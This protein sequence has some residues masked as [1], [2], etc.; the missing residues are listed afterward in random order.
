MA[1]SAG[2]AYD[3][4]VVGAGSAGC[5]LAARLSEAADR[6]VLLLEAGPELRPA[7]LPDEL[8]LLSKAI[9]WPFDWGDQVLSLDERPLFYGRGRGIGGS[10]GTNGAVAMRAEPEDFATWLP[11]W[12]WDDM[13]PCFRRL[14]HDLDFGS[15][16]YHGADGPV[17]I[18]RWPRDEWTPMQLAFHDACRSLGFPDCPDHNAPGTTGVGPIPMNRVGRERYSNARAYLEPARARPNLDVRADA[19][20]HSVL[21]PRGRAVGIELATGERISAGEVVLAAGVVQDPLLLWRSGIGPPAELAALGIPVIVELPAVGSH[22]TDHFV[23]TFA[24]EIDPATA[25]DDAPSLHTILRAT[26]PGSDRVHDLQLTPWVR[27]LPDGR[28]AMGISVSLQLPDGEGA[29]AATAADPESPARITWPFA[30][31]DDNVRR[32]RDGWRLAARVVDASGIALDRDAL[33]AEIERDD[34]DI[35]ALVR[36][37]HSA[38][39]HGVG[40]CRMGVDER[41]SVVDALGRVHG[42]SGLRIVDASIAPVVPRTNTHLLVTAMAERA[43]ETWDANLASR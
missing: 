5:V 32:V 33:R 3:T 34:A 23:V 4:I 14:E 22:V 20:V 24:H 38:F 30:A 15:E 43:V 27:R 35:D 16:P 18:V 8:R 1:P 7:A 37:T 6:R 28:R 42:I 12:Q 10:S 21:A 9:S 29:I 36:D 25:P 19:H 40:T 26:S 39:Y 41:S 31:I 11:G 2:S 13:L 17:P